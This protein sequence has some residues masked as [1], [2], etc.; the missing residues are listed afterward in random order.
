MAIIFRMDPVSEVITNVFDSNVYTN[1]F[2]WKPLRYVN[3]TI[4]IRGVGPL[5]CY[6]L[7][8]MQPKWTC[9]LPHQLHIVSNIIEWGKNQILVSDEN[10][11]FHVIDIQTGK[12]VKSYSAE[13]PCWMPLKQSILPINN[14][15]VVTTRE[16]NRVFLRVLSLN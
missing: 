4:L 3:D 12:I 10:S 7:S 9:V 1:G 2:D 15:L 5:Q 14:K 11:N 16:S 13:T 6:G 8:T